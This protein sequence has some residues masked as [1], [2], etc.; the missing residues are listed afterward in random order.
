MHLSLADIVGLP[1]H[2]PNEDPNQP[3]PKSEE[4]HDAVTD[5]TK[6]AVISLLHNI[7]RHVT[8]DRCRKKIERH[9]SV[10]HQGSLP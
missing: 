3:Q 6:E 4:D 5:K 1:A 8:S 7:Y 10:I 2:F 9:G